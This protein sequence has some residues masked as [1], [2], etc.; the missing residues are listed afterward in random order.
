MRVLAVDPG[1]ERCGWAVLEHGPTYID[2]G[3]I[4]FP[5][6]GMEFQKYRLAL[7]RFYVGQW[8]L[9]TGSWAPDVI[10]NEIIPAVGG[11]NFVAATQSYLANVVVTC[12]HDSAL[13]RGLAVAQQGATTV[14]KH[15][16]LKKKGK[17][18][19]KVQV[20]NGVL[21]ILPELKPRIKDWVKEFDEVDAIANGLTYLGYQ[22][23]DFV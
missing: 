23:T 20:R 4:R 6:D 12:L 19:T 22:V 10:I 1:A 11:G 3:I 7:E 8:D 17:K 21:A 5:R 18:V 15:I 16:A 2:S 9:M 14:H 13:R